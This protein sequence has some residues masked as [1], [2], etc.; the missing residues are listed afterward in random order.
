MRKLQQIEASEVLQGEAKDAAL[1]LVSAEQPEKKR[2]YMPTARILLPHCEMCGNTGHK[3]P[4]CPFQDLQGEGLPDRSLVAA[5]H[6]RNGLHFKGGCN[7][8]FTGC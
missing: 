5:A 2:P 7:M 6:F 1:A 8:Y 4:G 3:R